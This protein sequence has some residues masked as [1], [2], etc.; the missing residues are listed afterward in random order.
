MK[1]AFLIPQCYM[2]TT[3]Q[4]VVQENSSSEWA[5]GTFIQPKKTDDL[6]VLRDFPEL[7]KCL[8]QTLS[9]SQN[10]RSITNLSRLSMG[11]GS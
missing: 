4:E 2:E 1:Q 10:K 3:R 5:T 9:N 8:K 11:Y 6:R 7:N